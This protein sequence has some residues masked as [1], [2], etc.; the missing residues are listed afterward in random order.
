[1]SHQGP[2]S[3]SSALLYRRVGRFNLNGTVDSLRVLPLA[4]ARVL[5]VSASKNDSYL[6]SLAS[7]FFNP[8][9]FT[10][11]AFGKALNNAEM[12]LRELLQNTVW[13]ILRLK[14]IWHF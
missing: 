3:K 8:K 5:R 1:M 7:A 2:R 14:R 13:N 12:K 10:F 11:D 6:C 4:E 9:I